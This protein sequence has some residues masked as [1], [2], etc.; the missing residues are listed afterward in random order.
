MAF[1]T[2]RLAAVWLGLWMCAAAPAAAAPSSDLKIVILRHAE[3]P[4]EGDN[5]SC[6]GLNRALQLPAVL[7]RKFDRPRYVYVPSLS[8]GRSS[9]HARMFETVAPFA[10]KENLTVNSKFEESDVAAAA[11][12]VLTLD[13]TVLMV[14]EHSQ[15]P[16]LARA[17]GVP[18]PPSWPEDDFDT[19]WV[20]TFPG[21]RASMSIDRE[22]L[23][24][25]PDC[26]FR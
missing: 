10:I 16:P 21:G 9:K 26:A 19:I 23:A 22:G 25:A 20:I 6:K 3:K 8:N 5:L 2:G 12:E 14:W 4:K 7:E 11:T 1:S 24:P 13:G 17:L 15:I 18:Q